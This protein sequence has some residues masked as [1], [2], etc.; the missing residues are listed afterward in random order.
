MSDLMSIEM[1]ILWHAQA[2]R[3]QLQRE[4]PENHD[5]VIRWWIRMGVESALE[6]CGVI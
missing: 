6:K 1:I 5:F 4:K 2:C 3:E